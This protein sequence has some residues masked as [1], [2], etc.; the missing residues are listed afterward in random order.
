MDQGQINIAELRDEIADDRRL[1][2]VRAVAG[3]EESSGRRLLFAQ[4]TIGPQPE[5]WRSDNWIFEQCLFASG[6]MPVSEFGEVLQT[7]IGLRLLVGGVDANFELASGPCQWFRKPSLA[8]YEERQLPWPT[9]LYALS[10]AERNLHAPPGFLVGEGDT[11]TFPL[12]SA[13]FGAY[14]FDDFRVTTTRNPQLGQLTIC[15]IDQRGWIERVDQNGR[16]LAITLG[17]VGLSGSVLEFNSSEFRQSRR[18]RAAGQTII[19]LPSEACPPDAWVW[20]KQGPDWLDYRNLQRQGGYVS[21]GVAIS[22]DAAAEVREV[23]QS[24]ALPASSPASWLRARATEYAK[25][26]MTEY[27]NSHYH[28]FFLFAGLG[29]ELALKSRLAEVN[30]AFLA[31]DRV[32]ASAIAL[33]GASEDIRRLPPG[34]RTVGGQSALDRFVQLRPEAMWLKTGIAELLMHRNGEAHLGVIDATVRRRA[35]NSF[36]QGFTEVLDPDLEEFW[37]PHYEFVRA[38]LDENAEQIQQAVTFKISQARERFRQIASLTPPQ[39]EAIL[40]LVGNQLADGTLDQSFVACPACESQAVALG[41]N[42]IEYDEPDFDKDGPSG[43]RIL[44]QFAPGSMKCGVCGLVLES[45]DE[46]FHA[47][48]PVTW[49]NE[50]EDVLSA[51]H[52]QEAELRQYADYE[53]TPDTEY[54]EDRS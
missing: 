47:G 2:W 28:D 16:H 49:E 29:I 31:P 53:P 43:G 18:P 23:S 37:S 54:F 24:A 3:A 11:P 14:F 21:P 33:S 34:T 7:E 46:L 13:A 48:V 5:G 51:Y 40:A 27:V 1:A 25:R 44:V 36:L 30:L 22:D 35:F 32:F 15:R 52:Q 50:D 6:S 20:L 4:V 39:R 38:T 26:A 12:F 45:P 10:F 8:R 9:V 19:E 41:S 42:E 17:G